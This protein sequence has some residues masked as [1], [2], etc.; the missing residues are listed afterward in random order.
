[1]KNT[2]IIIICLAILT[3]FGVQNSLLAQR[4]EGSQGKWYGGGTLGFSFGQVTSISIMPEAAYAITEDL[5]I[6]AGIGFNYYQNNNSAPVRKITE[7]G[8]KLYLRYYVFDNIF[9]QVEYA[10]VYQNDSY[11]V[12]LSGSEWVYWDYFYGGVGYRSWVGG[13][14][15]MSIAILFDLK[16]LDQ[17]DF[18]YN[19]FIRFGIGIGF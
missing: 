5:F 8:G 11:Y 15:F 18:G 2:Q 10:P 6:G 3:L 16:N 13:N 9:G 7:W 14:S 12:G 17:I 19:P 1:M 4:Y